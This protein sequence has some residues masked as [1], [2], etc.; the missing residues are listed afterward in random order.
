MKKEIHANEL[1][2]SKRNNTVAQEFKSS[3]HHSL[4][5]AQLA[6]CHTSSPQYGA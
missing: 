2:I 3:V 6:T 5:I 1:K 4:H